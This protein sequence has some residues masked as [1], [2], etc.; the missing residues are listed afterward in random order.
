MVMTGVSS[1]DLIRR[2]QFHVNGRGAS[3]G[4]FSSISRTEA[5]HQANLVPH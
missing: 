4:V 1:G 5:F 3:S 2:I